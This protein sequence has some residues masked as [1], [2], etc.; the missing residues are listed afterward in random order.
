MM[1]DFFKFNQQ[2]FGNKLQGLF[3]NQVYVTQKVLKKKTEQGT[4]K[5]RKREWENQNI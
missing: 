4:E 3:V 2:L 1:S 5:E